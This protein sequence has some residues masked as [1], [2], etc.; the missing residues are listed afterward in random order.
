MKRADG[1][2]SL[3]YKPTGAEMFYLTMWKTA[4]PAKDGFPVC[5]LPLLL[6]TLVAESTP[7]TSVYVEADG[8]MVCGGGF[9]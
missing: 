1:R 8:K 5:S 4:C 6:N 3:R 2:I 7:F 9:K